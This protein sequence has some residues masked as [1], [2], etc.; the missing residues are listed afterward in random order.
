MRVNEGLKPACAKSCPTRALNFGDE[1]AMKKLAE[2]HLAA[3]KKKYGDKAQILDADDVRVLY[4]V[5]D[6][7][8]KYHEYA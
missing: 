2:E 7:K 1:E 6:D 5:V 3:A 4:L 8:K